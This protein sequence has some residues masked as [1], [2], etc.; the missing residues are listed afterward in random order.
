LLEDYLGSAQLW[1]SATVASHQH[2]VSTLRDDPLCLYRVQSL[3]GMRGPPPPRPRRH[4]SLDE[5]RCGYRSW[6]AGSSRSSAACPLACLAR[7]RSARRACSPEWSWSRQ[8]SL[9]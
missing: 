4:H 7:A 6:T 1:K 9:S 8:V 2:V 3:A 5:V